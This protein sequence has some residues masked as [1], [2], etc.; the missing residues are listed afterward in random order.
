MLELDHLLNIREVSDFLSVPVSTIRGWM[1]LGKIPF[2][3]FGEGRKATVRF[4]PGRILEW[5]NQLHKGAEHAEPNPSKRRSPNSISKV[6]N[7]KNEGFD[8]FAQS[9]LRGISDHVEKK[10]G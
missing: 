7:R 10:G 9:L 2:L 5:L 8:R 1:Y 3:K 6:K 4:E